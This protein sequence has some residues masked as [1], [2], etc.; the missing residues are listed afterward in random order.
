[1]KLEG[2]TYIEIHQKG[3]GIYH[4]VDH[5]RE[6]SVEELGEILEKI[7]HRAIKHGT[8]TMECKSGYGLSAEGEIK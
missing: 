6:S 1:M 8:T 2:A 4:T 3:G 7:V 5:V